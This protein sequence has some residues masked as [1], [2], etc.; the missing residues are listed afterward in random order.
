MPGIINCLPKDILRLREGDKS[1]MPNLIFV[2]I[3][4]PSQEKAKEIA[5]YLLGKDLI[6]C[7]NIFPISSL[8]WWKGKIADENEAVLVAKALDGKFEEIK[9]EVRKIHPY[10]VPC[11]IKIPV[12]A[13]EEYAKWVRKETKL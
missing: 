5:K 7:A 9:N 12:E 8:Y 13:N 11:I 4:N 10:S 6:A 1:P 2:Y 3:T